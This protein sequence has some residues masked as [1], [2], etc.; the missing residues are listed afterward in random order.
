MCACACACPLR[1][2][3]RVLGRLQALHWG[4]RDIQ[5][6]VCALTCRWVPFI[7]DDCYEGGGSQGGVGEVLITT[8]NNQTMNM[9]GKVRNGG[10]ALPKLR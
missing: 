9:G 5:A 1:K 7:M 3:E 2:R 4:R 6:A 10:T 8:T